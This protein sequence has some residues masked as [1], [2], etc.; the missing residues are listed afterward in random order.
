VIASTDDKPWTLWAYDRNSF[1]YPVGWFALATNKSGYQYQVTAMTLATK[2][3][4]Q[5]TLA[6]F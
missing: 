5:E 6:R 3:R 4:L 2:S 1:K